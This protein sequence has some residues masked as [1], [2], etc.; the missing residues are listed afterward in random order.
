LLILVQWLV[1]RYPPQASPSQAKPNP[2]AGAAA[3]N[4]Q[5]MAMISESKAGELADNIMRPLEEAERVVGGLDVNFEMIV[6]IA[7]TFA[8]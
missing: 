5:N 4:S 1:H 8:W 2:T 3:L 6:G 7:R